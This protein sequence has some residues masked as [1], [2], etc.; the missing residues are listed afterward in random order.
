ML[1]CVCVCVSVHVCECVVK[2]TECCCNKG[3]HDTL[4]PQGGSLLPFLD[5]VRGGQ[6]QGPGQQWDLSLDPPWVPTSPG[7]TLSSLPSAHHITH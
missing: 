2:A 7:V 6:G 3:T 5:P 1:L 4:P